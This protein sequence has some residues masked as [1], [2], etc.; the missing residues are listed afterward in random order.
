MSRKIVI[1]TDPGIDGAFA[2]A[3]ALCDPQLEV[4]GLAATAGNVPPDLATRNIH[5]VVEQLDPARWPRLGAAL[6][7]EY[8][9][10]NLELHGPDGL[11]G[12]DFPCARLHHPATSDKLVAE[13]VRNYPHEVTVLVLG[14][15]TVVARALDRD[16]E[17]A[18][19]V[20]RIIVLGGTRHEPGD[21][22]ACSDFHFSS[23]P[24]AARQ[25]LRSGATIT[26]LP[27]DVTTKL[28]L[29]PTELPWLLSATSRVGRFLGKVVPNGIGPSASHRG[30]EGV[31]LNDVVGVAVAALP[32]VVTTK[33]IYCDV[34][35]RGEL[36]RGACVF[37][38]RWS[39][40]EKPNVDVATSLDVAKVRQYVLHTLTAVEA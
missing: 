32:D 18:T 17:L 28:V 36:T 22:T 21:A 34:E 12:V 13:L 38:T 23:D 19:L 7:A 1:V 25:V 40:R 8:E 6:P 26:L 33:S 27:L 11:G 30:I 14:P 2:V 3:L 15:A 29:S 39:C 31:V 10:Y 20:D 37:D 5:I 35:T 16:P 9:R 24:L 4:L